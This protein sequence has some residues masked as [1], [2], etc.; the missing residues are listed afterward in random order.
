MHL[1]FINEILLKNVLSESAL[2]NQTSKAAYGE[3]TRTEAKHFVG[4]MD[5]TLHISK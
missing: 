2:F 3:E 5:F 4:T 1:V